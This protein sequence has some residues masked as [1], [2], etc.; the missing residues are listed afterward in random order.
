MATAAA[1]P[2]KLLPHQF[3]RAKGTVKKTKTHIER[4]KASQKRE[5]SK[6]VGG[7]DDHGK[8]SNKWP[9][10]RKHFLKTV[11]DGCAA[12]GAKQGLQVHHCVPFHDDPSKELDQSNFIALCEYVGG[13][14]CHEL[15]GHG[16]S[17]KKYN[18][19]VRADAA[20]LRKDPTQLKAIQARAMKNRR[21]NAP[22]N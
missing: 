9:T 13:L 21:D 1:E 3:H 20:A 5:R 7:N 16:G 15:I 8:R 18:P 2:P 17:F 6:L 22:G 10:A 4:V 12:C 11:T 19:N 14:E